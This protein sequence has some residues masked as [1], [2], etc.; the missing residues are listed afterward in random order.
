ML[1]DFEQEFD[2]I[3]QL[4]LRHHAHPLIGEPCSCK[5]GRNSRRNTICHDCFQ[6]TPSCEECF[7]QQHR[8]SPFHW[9]H[10]WDFELGFFIKKDISAL[11]TPF[12]L[13]F[14]HSGNVC[15]NPLGDINNK[16]I[17]MASNGV[18]ATLVRFCDCKAA[19]SKI[20]Q[21]C[22][23]RL[24]PSTTRS[25]TS[26]FTFEVLKSFHVHSLQ[27][28]ASAYDF[29]GAI[30]R[31]TDNVFTHNVPVSRLKLRISQFETQLRTSI[32]YSFALQGFGGTSRRLKGLDR[33][34]VSTTTSNGVVTDVQL[35]SALLLPFSSSIW[36]Q[37]GRNAHRN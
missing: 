20:E 16:F 7:I 19:P 2:N 27:S 28:K 26:A 5:S 9:A 31:L 21:L 23:A 34:M 3:V 36:R 4:L 32:N 30:Q 13:H 17:V 35:Y 6:S 29:I 14:N 37:T 11:S 10:V 22:N 15:P 8:L 1:G 24:F 33:R 25:P 12:S 18:H